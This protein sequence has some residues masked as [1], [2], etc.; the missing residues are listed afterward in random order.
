MGRHAAERPLIDLALF[1]ARKR[2]AVMFE[3]NDRVRRFLAHVL[4]RVL[5]AEPV[6]A[7]DRVV[8]VPAPVILPHVAQRRAD[9]TLRRNRM[10]SGWE[11]LADTGRLESGLCET[12]GCAQTG[13]TCSEYD[14]IVA[15]INKIMLTH[16]AAPNA[17]FNTANTLVIATT[18]WMNL[19]EI[20]LTT[21]RKGPCT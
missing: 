8:H 12:E 11:D 2:H 1:G 17:I 13:A 18:R 16:A 7:F 9:A 6:R 4:D 5:I 14:N 19:L 10:T 20:K 3:F 21:F 15:V